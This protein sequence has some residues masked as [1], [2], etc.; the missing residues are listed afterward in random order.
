MQ[1]GDNGRVASH[2]A[3]PSLTFSLAHVA[4][5]QYVGPKFANAHLEHSSKYGRTLSI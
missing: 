3:K 1:A 4:T 2:S 5:G